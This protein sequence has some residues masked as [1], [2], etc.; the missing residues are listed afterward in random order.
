MAIEWSLPL[1]GD[2]EAA[3]VDI[4]LT[5]PDFQAA[6][7][8]CQV[9]TD[10]VG[11][12]AGDQWIE[13][14]RKGG[15]LTPWQK[16]DKPRIDFYIFGANRA[17]ALDIGQMCM[18]TIFAAMGNYVGKGIRLV[19]GVVETGLTRTPDKQTDSARYVLSLR[20]TVVPQ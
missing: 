8:N 4:L 11:Y 19:S 20:L 9:S 5:D 12:Q 2:T 10:L 1:H 16:I 7:P 3:V 15:N 18:R 13:V 6:F 17:D 14:A